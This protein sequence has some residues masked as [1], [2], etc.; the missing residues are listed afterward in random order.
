[1]VLALVVQYEDPSD[2]T[3]CLDD[4]ILLIKE[5][6]NAYPE[7]GRAM[8][9]LISNN[10]NNSTIGNAWQRLLEFIWDKIS[11]ATTETFYKHLFLPYLSMLTAMSKDEKVAEY[12]FHLLMSGFSPTNEEPKVEQLT[13]WVNIFGALRDYYEGFQAKNRS[14]NREM[15]TTTTIATA[16]YPP[17]NN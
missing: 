16:T 10:N 13:T 8:T 4:F 12:V 17:M 1:M 9:N 5:I 14:I 15:T 3:D 2:A 11:G 7:Q 6:C